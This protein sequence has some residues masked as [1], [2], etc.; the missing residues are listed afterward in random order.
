MVYQNNILE[1]TDNMKK[2]KLHYIKKK[3]L[4]A[5]C[6]LALLSVPVCAEEQTAQIHPPGE[7]A[8]IQPPQTDASIPAGQRQQEEGQIS[9]PASSGSSV[10]TVSLRSLDAYEAGAILSPV[11]LDMNN[12]GI[13][14]TQREI[15]VGDAV[16]ER[17]NGKSYRD[18]PDI[19]LSRLRYLKILHYNFD[20]AIQVGEMIVNEAIAADVLVIFQKLF[21]YQYQIQSMYLVDNYWTGDGN[22][23]DTAS[24]EQNNTSAFNY[25]PITG[26]SSLSNHAFGCAIDINPQQNPYVWYDG[27]GN[28]NW[29]HA[30]ASDYIARDTGYAHVI[31]TTDLCY[32]LFTE[33]GF[34]WGGNWDNPRDYQHFERSEG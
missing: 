5:W 29:S 18:N 33:Y 9:A 34:S 6:V 13:Y 32:Q 30:N 25:R 23:T 16:Y 24:I 8:Q 28:P 2:K 15:Q 27:N 14:F 1:R 10:M 3:F 17:I 7:T 19:A 26:G 4:L 31:T 21:A 12:L 20:G 22:S 11:I